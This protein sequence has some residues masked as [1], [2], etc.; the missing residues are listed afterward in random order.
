MMFSLNENKILKNYLFVCKKSVSLISVII[1]TV[2]KIRKAYAF[3]WINK[4]LRNFGSVE[5]AKS[6]NGIGE[7]YVLLMNAGMDYEAILQNFNDKFKY[8]PLEQ[9]HIGENQFVNN[10]LFKI[11]Q[12]VEISLNSVKYLNFLCFREFKILVNEK[13]DF[14]AQEIFGLAVKFANL[15]KLYIKKYQNLSKICEK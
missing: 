13:I 11:Y 15:K 12:I 4:H 7:L 2:S 9:I 5:K 3:F 6:V 14:S 10:R 1:E 8:E